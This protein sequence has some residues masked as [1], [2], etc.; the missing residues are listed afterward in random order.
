MRHNEAQ[1]TDTIGLSRVCFA[2]RVAVNA[3]RSAAQAI[4][5]S[6]ESDA[7]QKIYSRDTLIPRPIRIAH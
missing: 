3:P 7:P 6:H 4:A 5:L 2:K 1:E